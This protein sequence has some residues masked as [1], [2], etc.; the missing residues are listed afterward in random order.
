MDRQALALDLRN[1][2]R[3]LVREAEEG[4]VVGEAIMIKDEED[5]KIDLKQS[6]PYRI[7]PRGY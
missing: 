1:L 7:A 5:P 2:V 3:H 6:M 4:F